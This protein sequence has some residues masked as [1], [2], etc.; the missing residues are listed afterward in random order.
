MS[1]H[2]PT[3]PEPVTPRP[4][5]GK[6][7]KGHIMLAAGIRRLRTL[8]GAYH[9]RSCSDLTDDKPPPV[10][11]PYRGSSDQNQRPWNTP[12]GTQ[13]SGPL[14]PSLAQLRGIH[15]VPDSKQDPDLDKASS[16]T[17]TSR[18]HTAESGISSAASALD[19]ISNSLNH[20]SHSFAVSWSETPDHDSSSTPTTL[21]TFD[22]S[23]SSDG[24]SVIGGGIMHIIGPTTKLM[25]QLSPRACQS[26]YPPIDLQSPYAPYAPTSPLSATSIQHSAS[27]HSKNNNT[28]GAFNK[29]MGL[30]HL[31][32]IVPKPLAKQHTQPHPITTQTPT[33]RSSTSTSDIH[34]EQYHSA[35]KKCSSRPSNEENNGSSLTCAAQVNGSEPSSGMQEESLIQS[36]SDKAA[37]STVEPTTPRSAGLKGKLGW[38]TKPKSQASN[39]VTCSGKIPFP[40]STHDDA[41]IAPKQRRER[42]CSEGTKSSSLQHSKIWALPIHRLRTSSSISTLIRGMKS[43][44]RRCPSETSFEPAPLSDRVESFY[45]ILDASAI[46]SCDNPSLPR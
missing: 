13:D 23:S 11:A 3:L 8:S 30:R 41:E 36:R 35:I 6:T 45:E 34:A 4:R 26:A 16:T 12:S 15:F 40:C 33:A 38:T 24:S 10:P 37:P 43:S 39:C 14:P 7:S 44:L 42:N 1:T 17:N 9:G 21:S 31:P 46:P 5:Q 22:D 19:N 27:N 2:H 28:H 32:S 25:P 29:R 18:P 20:R